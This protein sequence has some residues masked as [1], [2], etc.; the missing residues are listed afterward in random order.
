MVF[1]LIRH[2]HHLLTVIISIIVLRRDTGI[3]E[4]SA[5]GAAV[6][7]TTCP[8]ATIAIYAGTFSPAFYSI[9]N[10]RL[11]LLRCNKKINVVTDGF[12]CPY[13]KE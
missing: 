8:P 10:V 4:N 12:T 2:G 11:Q 6:L 5:A 1:G 7:H 13:Q 9:L 3:V